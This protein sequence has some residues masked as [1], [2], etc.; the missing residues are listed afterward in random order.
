MAQR[1]CNMTVDQ[2]LDDP[3]TLALM[4]ADGVDPTSLRALL[5]RTAR[6]LAE[7]EDAPILL[8]F[9]DTAMSHG[10]IQAG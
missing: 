8:T 3:M 1:G 9:S 10:G 4:R 2:L 6:R 7:A 5:A